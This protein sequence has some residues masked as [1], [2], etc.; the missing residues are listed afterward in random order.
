MLVQE[1][2]Q[3]HLI[4][5]VRT[6]ELLRRLLIMKQHPNLRKVSKR[7]SMPNL[8]VVSLS[9]DDEEVPLLS[10]SL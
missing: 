7:I 10:L 9:V 8:V 5:K 6:M 3:D 2:G 4:K 1:K